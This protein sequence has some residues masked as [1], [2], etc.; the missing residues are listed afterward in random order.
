MCGIYHTFTHF[1]KVLDIIDDSDV[2]SA[3]Q[4]ELIIVLEFYFIY[5]ILIKLCC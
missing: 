3:L 5:Q 1:Y 2:E 4:L